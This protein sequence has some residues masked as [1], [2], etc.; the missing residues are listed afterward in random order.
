MEVAMPAVPLPERPSLEQLKKQAKLLQRAVR[1]G[2]PKA[3]ALM[4][5]HQPNGA[6]AETFSLDAAQFVL[7]R[8]SRC[9]GP[10]CSPRRTSFTPVQAGR[11]KRT[12]NGAPVCIPNWANGGRC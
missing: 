5:E 3:V 8:T 1:S 7:A 2:H 9:P 6:A 11:T 12:S 4:A 10:L